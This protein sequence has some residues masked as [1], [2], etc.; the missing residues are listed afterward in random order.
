MKGTNRFKLLSIVLVFAY[1]LSACSGAQGGPGGGGKPESKEVAFTGTVE[2]VGSGQITVSGTV[3]VLDAKSMVDPN[4]QVG[5]IVKVEAQVS[6]DGAVIAIKV[7]SSGG[8]DT[9]T[10]SGNANDTNTNGDNSNTSDDN[11]NTGTDDNSNSN[12]NGNDNGTGGTEQEITGVV[13]A[14]SA[15]SVTVDGVEYKF[16]A[17]TEVKDPIFAGDTVKL[18]VLVG[19]DGSLTVREIEKISGTTIGDDNS[20]GNS[21]DDNSNGNSNDDNGND[22]NSNGNSNDDNG[23]DDNSN[24]SNSNDGGGDN[25]ND[26]NSN[27][28][29]N[30]NGG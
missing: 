13:S 24:D 29:S 14:I 30:S 9:N 7:E 21:N 1:I 25:G 3:V 15:S 5:D 16:D 28:G 10:N 23:N 19:S 6:A 26:D 27:S 17:S 18:H 8:D 2:S 12:A 4:I 20:N 11:S 22:D